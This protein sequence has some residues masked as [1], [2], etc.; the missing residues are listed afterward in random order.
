MS[1][2]I[3]AAATREMV[4]VALMVD[5]SSSSFSFALATRDVFFAR[6][7]LD[8]DDAD[9]APTRA[10]GRACLLPRVLLRTACMFS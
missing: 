1:E 9:D 7:G 6:A 3:A 5:V 10:A 8:D 4:D 2:A